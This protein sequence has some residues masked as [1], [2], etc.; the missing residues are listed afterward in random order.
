MELKN[1]KEWKNKYDYKN[2]EKKNYSFILKEQEL[3]VQ[4]RNI[5]LTK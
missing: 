1:S 2:E 5:S 4:M 3:F